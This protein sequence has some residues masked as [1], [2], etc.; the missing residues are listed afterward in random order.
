MSRARGVPLHLR[1]VERAKWRARAAAE[2][3]LYS[4]LN[5]PS[6]AA[7]E[8]GPSSAAAPVTAEAGPSSAA[9]P[10]TVKTPLGE[11]VFR[12]HQLS[13]R[14]GPP[15]LQRSPRLQSQQW[16]RENALG[17][18]ASLRMKDVPQLVPLSADP[19]G[20]DPRFYAQLGPE[21]RR[22]RAG[23]LTGSRFAT[24]IGFHGEDRL[25]ELWQRL[26]QQSQG[27][28][29]FGEWQDDAGSSWGHLY[30]RSALATYLTAWLLPRC[31]NS[32]V[33][34]TGFWPMQTSVLGSPGDGEG[35]SRTV[36]ESSGGEIGAS[37][38]AL[39]EGVDG[40]WPGGVV[41]EVKCPYRSGRP[42]AQPGIYARQ[43]RLSWP[44]W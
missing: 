4:G 7:A 14:T 44:P 22:R 36:Q 37:P 17:R 43:V 1:L 23:G 20:G 10:V 11:P 29:L 12:K 3:W 38:D 27:D 2:D 16:N 42:R 8:A 25:R 13:Q 5:T 28:E 21:W 26:A 6:T 39:V 35:G 34:E 41:V 40:L 31:A 33:H 19:S 32:R 24:A 30:E 9:A 15:V 18:L